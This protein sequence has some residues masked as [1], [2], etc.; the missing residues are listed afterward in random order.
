MTT[1]QINLVAN[2]VTIGQLFLQFLPCTGTRFDLLLIYCG[3]MTIR[4]PGL[5]SILWSGIIFIVGGVRSVCT[6][7]LGGLSHKLFLLRKENDR[8]TGTRF[9]YLVTNWIEA[10]IILLQE[11][12]DLCPG[13]RFKYLVANHFYCG[14]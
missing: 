10:L 4:V 6:G 11:D 12:E 14:T 3:R 8:C 13:T 9:K 2:Y 1:L 5:V 7:T